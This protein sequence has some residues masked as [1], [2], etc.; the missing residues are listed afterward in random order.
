MFLPQCQRP[1]FT[2]I[3]NNT[4]STDNQ[5]SRRVFIKWSKHCDILHLRSLITLRPNRQTC[6]YGSSQNCEK[7]LF[8]SLRLSVRQHALEQRGSHC[9]DFHEIDI[10][11]FFENLSRKFKFHW[12]LTRITGTLHEDRCTFIITS[13]CILLGMKN[14]SNKICSESQNTNCVFNTVL[15]KIVPFMTQRGKIWQESDRPQMAIQYGACV[16]RA[17]YLRLQTRTQNM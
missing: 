14:I 10:W 11:V 16:L 15:P 7:R 6:Y 4:Y 13:L 17:G 9:T 1:S 12:T 3:Q 8:T 5:N 2:P